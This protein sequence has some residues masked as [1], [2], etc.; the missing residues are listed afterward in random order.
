MKD[1]DKER[2]VR[3]R[4]ELVRSLDVAQVLPQLKR[5]DMYTQDDE[6]KILSDPRR[7]ERVV[8][9]LNILEKKS[10]ETFQAFCDILSERFPH[11]FLLLS[12]WDD[13]DFS[14]GRLANH[15]GLDDEWAILHRNR[16]Y[17]ISQI[18]SSKLIPLMKSKHVL[19]E[20][21]ER[22]ITNDANR[23]RR[24]ET[25]LDFL[26]MKPPGTYAAFLEAVGE[27]YPHVYLELTNE[28]GMDDW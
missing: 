23:A 18:D 3:A 11:L 20:D 1:S 19:T 13:E 2:L 27:I 8:L 17:L 15:A 16:E 28:G 24:T 4:P 9:F 25:F 6:N 10:P 14:G 21:Q 12:D 26:E 7:R 22:Q 5:P